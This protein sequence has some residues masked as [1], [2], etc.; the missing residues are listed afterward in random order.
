M[1]DFDQ[2]NQEAEVLTPEQ[3]H[4]IAKRRI[5]VVLIILCVILTILC[6]WALVERFVC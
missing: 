6:G 4:S 2:L 3:K 5:F 1:A